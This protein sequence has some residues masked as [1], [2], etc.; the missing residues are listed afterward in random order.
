MDTCVSIFTCIYRNI[1]HKKKNCEYI[2]VR[3]YMNITTPVNCSI[4]G[5]Y[6]NEWKGQHSMF[7]SKC[8]RYCQ[9]CCDSSPCSAIYMFHKGPCSKIRTAEPSL[10]KIRLCAHVHTVHSL[11]LPLSFSLILYVYLSIEMNVCVGF[12][13]LF[14]R[15]CVPWQMKWQWKQ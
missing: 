7:K 14:I 9:C 6:M 4:D 12:Y 11:S 10:A 15:I 5:E 1:L 8:I 13:H 2:T 3:Y